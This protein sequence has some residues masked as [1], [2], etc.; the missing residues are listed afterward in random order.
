[1]N[2]IKTELLDELLAGV[3]GPDDLLG[4]GGVF[5]QL[6]K[7]L[8]ERASGAELTHHLG[9]EKGAAPVGRARGN[10]RDHRAG[11]RKPPGT[12]RRPEWGLGTPLMGSA[13]ADRVIGHMHTLIRLLSL[14]T[15][16]NLTMR[17]QDFLPAHLRHRRDANQQTEHPRR[18]SGM[19][20]ATGTPSGRS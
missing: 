7:A 10:S 9:D 12:A 18:E 2:A 17:T 19:A 8:M 16:R 1:M 4:D 13:I 6:K 20:R 5:R 14:R 11:C 3:S 15:S